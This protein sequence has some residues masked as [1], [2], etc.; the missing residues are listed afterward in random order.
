MLHII[1]CFDMILFS[2]LNVVCVKKIPYFGVRPPDDDDVRTFFNDIYIYYIIY[3]CNYKQKLNLPSFVQSTSNDMIVWIRI[4]YYFFLI[5]Y[6]SI[7]G[8]VDGSPDEISAIP[9]YNNYNIIYKY[10]AILCLDACPTITNEGQ[11]AWR[12]N[13]ISRVWKLVENVLRVISKDVLL[14]RQ[15]IKILVKKKKK[16]IRIKSSHCKDYV[17]DFIILCCR[18]L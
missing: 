17:F 7:I 10:D 9:I 5:Y 11:K 3:K 1:L 18:R 2:D 15:C 12:F 6:S 8:T 4:Y 14:M 13:N 16:K